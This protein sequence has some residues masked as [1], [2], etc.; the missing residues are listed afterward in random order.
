MYRCISFV[1][2][3]AAG[4]PFGCWCSIWLLVFPRYAAPGSQAVTARF[5]ITWGTYLASRK[6]IIYALIDGRGSGFQGDKIKHEVRGWERSSNTSSLRSL[7][8]I[9]L[10]ELLHVHC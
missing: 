7:S 10:T 2:H 1:L 6:D 5:A 9:S 4:V 8:W 3:L